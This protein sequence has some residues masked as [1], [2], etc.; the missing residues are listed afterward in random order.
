MMDLLNSKLYPGFDLSFKQLNA[1]Q[2]NEKGKVFIV[3]Y[4][5]MIWVREAITHLIKE[6]NKDIEVEFVKPDD[7]QLSFVRKI[8]GIDLSIEDSKK[9][10]IKDKRIIGI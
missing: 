1:V 3:D 4:S 10:F 9:T 5:N 8:L 6:L 2:K 7:K